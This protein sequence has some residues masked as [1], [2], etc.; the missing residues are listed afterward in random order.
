MAARSLSKA[1]R[2][3]EQD[4]PL[5]YQKIVPPQ[6][7]RKTGSVL[8]MQGMFRDAARPAVSEKCYSN[9]YEVKDDKS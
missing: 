9:F 7:V 6:S 2:A 8:L 5:Q 1:R 4:S 3:R